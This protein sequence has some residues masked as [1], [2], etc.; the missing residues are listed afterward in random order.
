MVRPTVLESPGLILRRFGFTRVLTWLT[1]VMPG[2][3]I[4]DPLTE[5]Y[6]HALRLL[7]AYP[8]QSITLFDAVVAAAKRFNIEVWT[9]DHHFDLLRVAT[10]RPRGEEFARS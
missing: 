1:T 6:D 9:D 4:V 8:D 5:D 7:R 10:W 2:I 3:A